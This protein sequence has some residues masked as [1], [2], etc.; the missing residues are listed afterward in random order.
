M[1]SQDLLFNSRHQLFLL[2][3]S[4]QNQLF[5]FHSLFVKKKKIFSVTKRGFG[6]HL[7]GLAAGCES[8]FCERIREP[9]AVS[10]N[11]PPRLVHVGSQLEDVWSYIMAEKTATSAPWKQ[12]STRGGGEDSSAALQPGSDKGNCCWCCLIKETPEMLRSCTRHLN[13]LIINYVGLY[14]K[15][16]KCQFLS[17]ITLLST[18]C[19]M[20]HQE[21]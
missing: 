11:E 7:R 8:N 10:G 1:D 14:C 20:Y 16:V 5:P 13:S 17:H 21:N 19:S 15:A 4:L 12:G 3:T 6:T 2:G 9:R 18:R